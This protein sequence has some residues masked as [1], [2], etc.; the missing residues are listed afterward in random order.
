M[1]RIVV[2]APSF[3]LTAI[4]AVVP[5]LARAA[6]AFP[7]VSVSAVQM[8]VTLPSL[9]A[10]PV[11]LLSGALA[12]VFTKKKITLVSLC[13]MLAGGLLPLL[14]HQSLPLLMAAAAMFGL[15][16][17]GVSPMTTALVYEHYPE[18]KEI[19]LGYMG[20]ALGAGGM[21]FSFLG[22]ALA[23]IRWQY[24]YLSYLLLIPVIALVLLLPKGE[25]VKTETRFR[26]LFSGS[27][28][29]YL[30]QCVITTIGFNVFNTNIAMYIQEAGLG[31]ARASGAITSLYSAVS[32]VGGLLAGRIM[33]KLQRYTLP[34]VF[35]VAGVGM[36]CICAGGSLFI[37]G[38]G[39]FLVGF[40]FAM[41]MPAGYSRA[42]SAAPAA[43][44]TMAIAV[45]CCSHQL[46]QF[47][48]PFAING[49]TALAGG[50]ISFKFLLAGGLLL[51]MF[52]A[53]FLR[54]RTAAPDAP[55]SPS[56]A[57][58]RTAA[59]EGRTA[60]ARAEEDG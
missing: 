45:Y 55:L 41:F 28:V 43:M 2:L 52:V 9:V 21:V 12:G 20:A 5:A 47:L 34:L 31:G 59:A 56:S 8:L 48:T 39:A 15:G 38:A 30:I 26:G 25:V 3:V 10:F 50:G 33:A 37:V 53:A 1:R 27:L 58:G 57:E 40:T 14:V 51:I 4:L 32:V 16:L 19:M 36:L 35:A 22:G 17:G 46:G 7:G 6:D 49:A 60:P 11:I 24:A 13:L 44:A 54:E 42:T 18:E 29:Y 23:S